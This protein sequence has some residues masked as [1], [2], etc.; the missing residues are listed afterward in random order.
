VPVAA[1]PVAAPPVAAPPVAAP[2]PEPSSAQTAAGFGLLTVSSLPRS[3]VFVDGKFVR[4]TPLF[5]SQLPAGTH[6][7]E[8]RTEQ[9]EVHRFTVEISQGKVINRVWSF[10]QGAWVGG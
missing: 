3:K 4:F 2:P 10:N 7:V 5:R 6:Q 9:G 1:P 8:L